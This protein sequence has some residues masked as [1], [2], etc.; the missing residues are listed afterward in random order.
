MNLVTDAKVDEY[1]QMFASKD[2]HS[3]K[4][5][6]AGLN[7]AERAGDWERGYTAT[8]EFTAQMRKTANPRERAARR[9]A[10]EI[11]RRRSVWSTRFGTA[12]NLLVQTFYDT[13]VP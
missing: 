8:Y 11:S 10:S 7:A 12:R 5:M 2:P 3:V 4:L 13:T 6:K 1:E 9:S